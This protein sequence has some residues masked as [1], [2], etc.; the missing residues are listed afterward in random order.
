MWQHFESIHILQQPTYASKYPPMQGLVL[1]FGQRVFHE[2]WIGVWL[3]E[4]I[5]CTAICWMLQG[6][7]APPWALLGALLA[8][9]RLGVASYWMN[10]YWGGAVAAIGGALVLGAAPRIARQRRF[11]DGIAFGVGLVILMN[12]RPFEG[13]VLACAAGV[14]MFWWL[15]KQR[16]PVREVVLQAMAPAAAV[17]ILGAAGMAYQNSHV[18]GHPTE[19]P[20]AAYNQQYAAYPNFIGS[21]PRTDL[22]YRHPSIRSYWMDYQASQWHKAARAPISTAL[23]DM[24]LTYIV[25]FGMAPLAA[26]AL[27]WPFALTTPGEKLTAVLLITCLGSTFLI[28]GFLPHYIAPI[29]GLAFLRLTQA[30]QRLYHW[31]P[32]GRPLGFVFT[33]LVIGSM[34]VTLP[35]EAGLSFPPRLDLKRFAQERNSFN[36][37]LSHQLVRYSPHHDI[38]KE[39]V[40]N[41]ADI[42]HASVVW[43]QE[44]GPTED[45]ELLE[46]FTG[47]HV[48]LLHADDDPPR[49]T[50]YPGARRPLLSS[51]T[52][53]QHPN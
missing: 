44:M 23:L 45:R 42:D 1:A 34:A 31:R 12:S 32:A 21:H 46:Y 51:L 37:R 8:L 24:L 33:I 25:W 47:R 43:A 11:G 28:L 5:M 19:L 9:L 7:L 13:F 10:S 35:S 38:E 27:L 52:S 40:F 39:W 41:A 16:A 14:V 18:T 6:W 26:I 53:N 17:L 36:Q 4:G 2:P 15:W 3:S 29:A 22:V 30:L 20:Y 49:L 50:P 48:W